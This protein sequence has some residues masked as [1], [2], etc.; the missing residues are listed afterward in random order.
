MSRYEPWDSEILG[1][2]TW[3]I[4]NLSS[5]PPPP[6][7]LFTKV[8]LS[9][10]QSLRDYQLAGFQAISAE[11]TLKATNPPLSSYT[12]SP[13][14]FRTATFQDE[15][16]LFALARTAF[17][18]SRFHA[19]PLIPRSTANLSRASWVS[20][21]LH[22]KRG[23]PS[24]IHLLTVNSLIA[25]FVI[26]ALDNGAGI[27]DLIAVHPELRSNGYGKSLCLYALDWFKS[28]CST[29]STTTQLTNT[30][31]LRMYLSV[32][33]RPLSSHLILRRRD[34]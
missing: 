22:D 26:C 31:A 6:R 24:E 27:I 14:A 32:G 2:P 3:R 7:Y 10:R 21:A 4:T 19:D 34:V 11:I 9:D 13:L 15:E 5:L 25:G 12:V 18:H 20:N 1:I 30:S 17:S 8:L 33:F 23:L 29:V 28:R 16:D